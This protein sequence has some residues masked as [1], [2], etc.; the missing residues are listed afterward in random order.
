MNKD[1]A[2]KR[3]E[4][5]NDVY[6]IVADKLKKEEEEHLTICIVTDKLINEGVQ[7][8]LEQGLEQK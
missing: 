7:Q 4:E 5:H 3:L 2:E 6:K 8:G 1:I